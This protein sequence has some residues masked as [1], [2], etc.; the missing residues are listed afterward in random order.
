MER[1]DCVRITELRKHT[2]KM[3][4]ENVVV[5]VAFICSHRPANVGRHV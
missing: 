5:L 2:V 3:C 1:Y 4:N